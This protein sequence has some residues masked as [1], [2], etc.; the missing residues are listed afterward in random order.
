[1]RLLWIG[2]GFAALGV[3][4]AG[5]VLP[6]IPTVP[7]L[8]L[9]AFCFARSS[10]ALHHWLVTHPVYGPH[11]Q[12]WRDRGAIRPRA[13]RLATVS[14]AAAFALS[15]ALGLRPAILAIQAIVLTAVLIFI[16]SRPPG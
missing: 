8:L 10:P 13:K 4:I 16:W 5:I 7:L 12:D 11:I 6:L 2:L 3:G 1:M 14:I 15:V 9:A